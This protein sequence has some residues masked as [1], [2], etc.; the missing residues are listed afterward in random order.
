LCNPGFN[1]AR[2]ELCI[3]ARYGINCTLCG[4]LNGATCSTGRAGTGCRCIGNFSGKTCET[5]IS[6]HF[7]NNCRNACL[8]ENGVC[9]EGINGTGLCRSCDT[10]FIGNLCDTYCIDDTCYIN[11][12][13][14]KTCAMNIL[15]LNCSSTQNINN[16]TLVFGLTNQT[17]N[18]QSTNIS[19]SNFTVNASVI[20]FSSSLLDINGSIAVDNSELTLNHTSIAITN[21]L[22]L[23]N[24]LVNIDT[25][26]EV[27]VTQCLVA[28]NSTISIDMKNTSID[29]NTQ[30][31]S[32]I[33]FAS[34]CKAVSGLEIVFKNKPKNECEDYEAKTS[35]N[36][37]FILKIDQ[38]AVNV[39]EEDQTLITVLVIVF[40]VVGAIIIAVVVFFIVTFSKKSR[41]ELKT[42]KLGTTIKH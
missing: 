12:T 8:C 41:G 40:S 7:G 27:E 16:S 30:T 24:S 42:L 34:G 17:L 31:K 4:C 9:N 14:N 29:Q 3:G 33:K 35:D 36:A 25:S 38:C 11:C 18:L 22:I 2:C 23:N 5:C 26:T 20:V 1:G 21:N 19:I 15:E 13:C 28:S 32:L 10:H 37:I 39:K 6:G